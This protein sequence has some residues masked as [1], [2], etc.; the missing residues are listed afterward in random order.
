M[1]VVLIGYLL[2]LAGCYALGREVAT[3]VRSSRW[4]EADGVVIGWQSPED[5]TPALVAGD[6]GYL[7]VS[8]Q[9]Q[10]DGDVTAWSGNTVPLWRDV[11][12]ATV[13]VTYDPGE[14]RR[15]LIDRPKGRPSWSAV[16]QGALTVAVGFALAA[17]S[18]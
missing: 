7:R 8:Y 17:W 18:P 13:R 3:V 14:P 15:V 2:V 16:I 4:H 9:P 1:T 10:G 6:A 12:G 5:V 11:T